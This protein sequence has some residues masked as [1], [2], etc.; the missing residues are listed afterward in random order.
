MA[1]GRQAGRLRRRPM[2]TEAL[3]RDQDREVGTVT[4]AG[5]GGAGLL[6]S[7]LRSRRAQEGWAQEGWAHW[8]LGGRADRHTDL[9]W[10]SGPALMCC[11]ALGRKIGQC[12]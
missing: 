8:L 5:A 11:V 4:P 12:L 1:S 9:G 6:S 2:L 7:S 3:P 10:M